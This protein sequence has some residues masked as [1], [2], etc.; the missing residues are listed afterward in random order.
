MGT[1]YKLDLEAPICSLH[2]Y[3]PVSSSLKQHTK[4]IKTHFNV[5]ELFTI[6]HIYTL[7][8]WKYKPLSLFLSLGVCMCVSV[9]VCIHSHKYMCS[10]L[11]ICAGACWGSIHVYRCGCCRT[12]LASVLSCWPLWFSSLCF[13][14]V[15]SHLPSQDRAPVFMFARQAL[16]QLSYHLSP[17]SGFLFLMLFCLFVICL[18]M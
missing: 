16:F 13:E 10:K 15:F 4:K 2:F 7:D 9:G 1:E 8:L 14:S 18:P 12:T 11:H 6:N 17:T 5:V 3:E